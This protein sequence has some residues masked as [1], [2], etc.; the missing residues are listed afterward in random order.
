MIERFG[1]V[2]A[3]GREFVYTAARIYN[4]RD[5]YPTIHCLCHRNVYIGIFE[6]SETLT[7]RISSQVQLNILVWTHTQH[8]VS[9]IDSISWFPMDFSGISCGSQM[10][11]FLHFFLTSAAIFSTKICVVQST[12]RATELRT[13]NS[14]GTKK[15][16]IRY[17]DVDRTPCNRHF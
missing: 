15:I 6:P 2:Q 1:P 7:C 10:T 11:G 3:A 13:S 17:Q 16:Q 8:G 12:S 4:G 5:L 14:H 9:W